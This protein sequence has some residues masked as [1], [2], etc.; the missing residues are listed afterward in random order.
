MCGSICR[1]GTTASLIIPV[2]S[3]KVTSLREGGWAGEGDDGRRRKR[4]RE[5]KGDSRGEKEREEEEGKRDR[6][7]RREKLRASIQTKRQR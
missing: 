2:Q 7:E 5:R 1:R 6:G 3:L 4:N